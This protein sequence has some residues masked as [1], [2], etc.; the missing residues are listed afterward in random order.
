[1]PAGDFDAPVEG[2]DGQA[3]GRGERGVVVKIAVVPSSVVVKFLEIA[4]G[5]G[6]HRG[7]K[8]RQQERR[9]HIC[10]FSGQYEGGRGFVAETYSGNAPPGTGVPRGR[11]NV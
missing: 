1:V 7:G 9:A 6:E 5:G 8:C 2:L 3:A 11:F 4:G 10:P